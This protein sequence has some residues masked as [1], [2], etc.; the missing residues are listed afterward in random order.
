MQP[1]PSE[2][3]RTPLGGALH[4]ASPDLSDVGENRP[5]AGMALDEKRRPGT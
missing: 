2:L 1:G 5:F 4:S 3:D